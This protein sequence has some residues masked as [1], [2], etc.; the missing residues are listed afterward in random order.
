MVLCATSKDGKV[1]LLKPP[2][3]AKVGER[4]TIEG[5][6][7]LDAD[8]KLNEKTGKA[9]LEA[10]KADMRTT[11]SCT[12]AYKGAAWL[13]SAGPITCKTSDGQISQPCLAGARITCS[14]LAKDT[15]LFFA[16]L[17]LS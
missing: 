5:V 10:V 3:G 11:A 17:R 12:A 14:R 8:E 6:E 9:P 7:M 16:C 2:A 13:T 1:E 15:C 4:V